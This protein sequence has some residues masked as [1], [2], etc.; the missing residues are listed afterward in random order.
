[1]HMAL[2]WVNEIINI[3]ESSL[4][5]VEESWITVKRLENSSILKRYNYSLYW[6]IIT[7]ATIGYGDVTPVN[8]YEIIFTTSDCSSNFSLY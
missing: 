7:M 4:S 8:D 2:Y 5:I 1:M 6:A 3:L